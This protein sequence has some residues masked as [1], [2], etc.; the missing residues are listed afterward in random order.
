MVGETPVVG[1]KYRGK[2]LEVHEPSAKGLRDDGST[3]LFLELEKAEILLAELQDAVEKVRSSELVV[4]P[5]E[6]TH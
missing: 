2:T 5:L 1:I 4:D 6:A 3:M